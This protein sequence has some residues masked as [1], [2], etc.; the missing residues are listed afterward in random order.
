MILELPLELQYLILE[1]IKIDNIPFYEKLYFLKNYR[2]DIDFVYFC[3]NLNIHIVDDE[4]NINF[5]SWFGINKPEYVEDRILHTIYERPYCMNL[6]R[7]FGKIAQIIFNEIKK[8]KLKKSIVI[9]YVNEFAG[10]YGPLRNN[11]NSRVNIHFH[12]LPYMFN[13]YSTNNIL[14]Y[15]KKM[16]VVNKNCVKLN[17]NDIQI[18]IKKLKK[19]IVKSILNVINIYNNSSKNFILDYPTFIKDEIYFKLCKHIN[20]NRILKKQFK[21]KMITI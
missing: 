17:L 13:Y 7:S 21:K 12:K 1:Y 2:F 6:E 3:V 4:L 19:L 15:F 16:N 14:K 11:W 20:I 5:S 8:F 10:T 18:A 9:D